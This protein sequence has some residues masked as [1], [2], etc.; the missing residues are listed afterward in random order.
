MSVGPA[1]T[2]TTRAPAAFAPGTQFGGRVD[3]QRRPDGEQ[4]VALLADLQRPVD[5]LRHERLAEG[6]RV[7]L[8]DPAA[9]EAR[10]IVLAG[11]DP[12][13]RLGHRP[14]V[15]AAPAP[16]PPHR[17]VDLDDQLGVGARPLVQPVDVLGDDGVQLARAVAARRSRR[18]RRSAR[19]PN[20][21]DW[22][23]DCATPAG[24]RPDRRGSA[25]SS[26]SS[27]RPGFFVHTPCGPRKSGMPESVEIPA[28]VSTVMRSASSIHAR[29][30]SRSSTSEAVT[31]PVSPPFSFPSSSRHP[32]R[33]PT[34]STP[35]RSHPGGPVT[36]HD[37]LPSAAP[38]TESFH[39]PRPSAS[40]RG[41][42]PWSTGAVT[43]PAPPTS[44]SSGCPCSARRRRG[45]CGGSS[46]GST[47]SRTAMSSTSRRPPAVSG[48]ASPRE[49]RRRSPRP[50]IAA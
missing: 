25:G 24:G 42:T 41:T 28:P 33:V 14:A 27:P 49:W 34:S 36:I 32:W 47:A 35:D 39:C 2:M 18:G 43:T 5:H 9:H 13:E 48:S 22:R 23:C 46:P 30:V 50:C 19:R 6:D 16:R 21:G 38:A 40:R 15:V 17:A 4:E 8:E 3:A 29:T 44:S 37:P 11:P 12:L 10:R 26:P 45:C 20:A 1:L 31:S 7:A